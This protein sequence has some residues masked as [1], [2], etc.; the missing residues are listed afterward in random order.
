MAFYH[1]KSPILVYKLAEF[2][3]STHPNEAAHNESSHLNLRYY[4]LVF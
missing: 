4:S 3:T 1:L 2:V